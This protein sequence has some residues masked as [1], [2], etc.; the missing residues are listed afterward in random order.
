M[1]TATA[2]QN[3]QLTRTQQQAVTIRDLLERQ[4]KQVALALP[5]H[6]TPDRM[7]RVIMTSI[8]KTPRLL[9]C[10]K[11]SLLG[12]VMQAAQLGLEPDGVLGKAYLI[13]RKRKGV[14]ECN[15]QAGYKGLIDLAYRSGQVAYIAAEV[16]HQRDFL[17]VNLGTDR[18]L[19]HKP[20]EPT[21]D[22]DPGLIRAFYA[23]AKLKD[24]TDH[25]VF[26]WRREVD[27]IKD[28]FSDAADKENPTAQYSPWNTNELTYIEMGKKTALRRLCKT[29][30]ASTE[31]QSTVAVEERQEAGLPA[32]LDGFIDIPATDADGAQGKPEGVGLQKPASKLDQIVND[33]AGPA[34]GAANG[35]A[36]SGTVT[37]TACD[38][39]DFERLEILGAE[40][41]VGPKKWRKQIEEVLGFSSWDLL[42]TNRLPEIQAWI[43]ATGKKPVD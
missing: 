20:F 35:T 11:E 22:E 3:T 13:P 18:S 8:Q 38:K 19:K 21:E 37:A 26:M 33:K 16:V 23:V 29:L 42:T 32:D 7:L 31:L 2:P 12:A 30:P 39:S 5:K 40:Y 41:S 14:W 10:T 36:T 9:E 17:D 27:R 24:G 34:A 6:L 1:S 28:E 25:F 4:K 43:K 15:F